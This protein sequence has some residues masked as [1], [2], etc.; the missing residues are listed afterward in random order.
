MAKH[1]ALLPILA[2]LTGCC[3]DVVSGDGG[4][5]EVT[6]G[7]TTGTS[8]ACPQPGPCMTDGDC[9]VAYCASAACGGCNHFAVSKTLLSANPCLAEIGPADGPTGPASTACQDVST[10][11]CGCF[12]RPYCVPRCFS[13]TCACEDAGGGF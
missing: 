4:I 10:E 11:T 5:T 8:V 2:V 1:A 12:A 6:T 7:G 13:E 3:L 9:V